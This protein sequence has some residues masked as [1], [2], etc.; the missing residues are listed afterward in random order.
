ME[1][2]IFTRPYQLLSFNFAAGGILTIFQQAKN[3][4][5]EQF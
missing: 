5:G 4:Q 1:F 3:P 2:P